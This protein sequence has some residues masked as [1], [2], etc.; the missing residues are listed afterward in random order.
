MDPIDINILLE[1]A[2]KAEEQREVQSRI[3][4]G[5][6]ASQAVEKGTYRHGK[7]FEVE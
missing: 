4:K 2:H 6:G 1:R 7:I 5:E 3:R